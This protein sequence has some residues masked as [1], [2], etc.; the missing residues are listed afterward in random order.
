AGHDQDRS[1]HVDDLVDQAE[2]LAG[3]QLAWVAARDRRRPAVDAGERAGARDLPRDGERGPVEVDVEEAAAPGRRVAAGWR[4][5]PGRSG[6]GLTSTRGAKCVIAPPAPAHRYFPR[7]RG[8]AGRPPCASA[9]RHL[10]RPAAGEP[11]VARP[12]ER[13]ARPARSAR[14]AADPDWVADALLDSTFR[15]PPGRRS[16]D[17]ISL[18]SYGD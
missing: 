13:H 2:R 16:R 12:R 15:A 1:A 10:A 6:H 14:R 8:A 9:R 17:G 18:P 5:L 4:R 3:G 7:M 11:A